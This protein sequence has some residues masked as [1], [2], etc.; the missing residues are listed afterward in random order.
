MNIRRYGIRL[1]L[2]SITVCAV[3][4]IDCTYS[5]STV[6]VK[7]TDRVV[8]LWDCRGNSLG[9]WECTDQSTHASRPSRHA[10]VPLPP[11]RKETTESSTQIEVT[12]TRQEPAQASSSYPQSETIT[13]TTEAE[14][15]SIPAVRNND[16]KHLLLGFPS[17]YYAVQLLAV[18]NDST[19]T[20]YKNRYPEIQVKRVPVNYNGDHFQLLI[21][22][23]YPSVSAAMQAIAQL[24]AEL[25][26]TPWIRPLAPLQNFL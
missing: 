17:H 7:K 22:G 5:D 16:S 1:L 18:K 19:I 12:T 15:A 21:L 4:S 24:P 3:V 6:L 14:I 13:H 20:L 23:I 26:P 25:Q 9:E 8:S 11:P 2:V 10:H